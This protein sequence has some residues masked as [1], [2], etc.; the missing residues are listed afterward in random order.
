MEP[1]RIDSK[2]EESHLF[3][4]VDQNTNASFTYF[5]IGGLLVDRKWKWQSDILPNSK[6]APN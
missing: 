3:N 4:L 2:D 1:L 6:W 5:H